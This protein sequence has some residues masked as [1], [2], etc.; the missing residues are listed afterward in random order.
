MLL[1]RVEAFLS[2]SVQEHDKITVLFRRHIRQAVCKISGHRK[3]SFR[4]QFRGSQDLIE[5]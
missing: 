2:I 1:G 5:N 3:G 4:A